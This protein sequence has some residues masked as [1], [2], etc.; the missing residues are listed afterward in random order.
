MVVMRK[1][2]N[3]AK[4]DKVYPNR[5][6]NALKA[7]PYGVT[8]YRSIDNRNMELAGTRMLYLNRESSQE[9]LIEF[10]VCY[11]KSAASLD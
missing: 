10:S 1:S 2:N 7:L 6:G 3:W 5:A 4:H 8:V 9:C 11:C